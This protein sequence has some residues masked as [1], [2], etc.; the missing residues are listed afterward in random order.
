[1][2]LKWIGAAWWLLGI[3]WAYAQVG[4]RDVFPDVR[5]TNPVDLVAIAPAADPQPAEFANRFYVVEQAGVIRTFQAVGTAPPAQVATFLDIRARVTA[6]GERGLLGLALH[7]NFVTNGL[8]YVNYTRTFQGRLQTVVARFRA[9]ATQADPASETVLLAF[10]QPFDNHNGGSLAFDRDGFLLIA[11]GDGGSGGDPQ[12]NSQNLGNL[13]GKILR[14]DVDRPATGQPYGI[15]AS[16]PFANRAGARPEIYAY[17]LRNPWKIS[18]DRPTNQLWAAD[19]GQNAQEEVNLIE[20]GG[21]YGWRILEGNDCFNPATNCDRTSLAAPVWTYGHSNG[22]R[23]IT[24]GHVYRGRDLPL[25]GRYIYGDYISGNVWAL[26][27]NPAGQYVN[28][29]LGNAGGLIS[30]FGA[31]PDGELY[32][33][34]HGAGGRLL[35]LVPPPP[36]APSQL[37]AAQL[38]PTNNLLTWT[39]NSLNETGFRIE[40]SQNATTNFAAIGTV[41]AN[42]VIYNDVAA[43]VSVR[44][45]YRVRAL[46]PGG[47]SG[48]SNVADVVTALNNPAAAV[49]L[50]LRPNPARGSVWVEVPPSLRGTLQLQVLDAAGKP[51]RTPLGI[52][53]PDEGFYLDLQGLAKGVHWLQISGQGQRLVQRLVVE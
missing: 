3:N 9:S 7:P 20:N 18:F 46:G 42:V 24:G 4:F 15:P 28:Q 44:Y 5:F 10:D 33:V 30:A 19:V 25:A 22:D 26:S 49:H 27:R 52:T 31:G 2:K 1:M 45:F 32:A 23:S 6:G 11:S 34:L 29:L 53:P 50:R 41:A 43:Q 48:P 51:V 16:N 36:T 39:D 17:G 47:D 40:R 8:L 12:N 13:L 38:S 14:I 37:V 35:R 21:N